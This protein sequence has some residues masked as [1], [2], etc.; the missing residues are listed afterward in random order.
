MSSR[1][2][3]IA[4]AIGAAQAVCAYCGEVRLARGVKRHESACKQKVGRERGASTNSQLSQ[5]TEEL[6]RVL[7]QRIVSSGK[8]EGEVGGGGQFAPGPAG[9]NQAQGEHACLRCFRG[10]LCTVAH[11]LQ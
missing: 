3:Q 2:Y 10:F 5:G 7:V 1:S 11:R 8:V 9:I 6:L 4:S